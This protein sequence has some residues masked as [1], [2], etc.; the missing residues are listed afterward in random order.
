MGTVAKPE[1]LKFVNDAQLAFKVMMDL[2]LV[3]PE[4]RSTHP[5]WFKFVTTMDDAQMRASQLVAECME[6]LESG[7]AD[8]MQQQSYVSKLVDRNDLSKDEIAQIMM[9]LLQA[10]VDTQRVLPIGCSSTLQ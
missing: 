9:F 3:Q 7:T 5:A 1:D 6:A 8:E 4:E 10:G 2:L